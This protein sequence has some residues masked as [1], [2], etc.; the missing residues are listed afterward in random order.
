MKDGRI[1]DTMDY[2][3]RDLGQAWDRPEIRD[4]I[5]A[6]LVA[7]GRDQRGARQRVIASGPL[8]LDTVERERWFGVHKRG[9]EEV[10]TYL[11]SQG[12]GT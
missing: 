7:V 6:V 3:Y 10:G 4:D 12:L 11:H 1:T 5:M 9:L 2:Q 8:P